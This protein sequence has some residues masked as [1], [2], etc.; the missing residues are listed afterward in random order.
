[1][2]S[3]SIHLQLNFQF[4]FVFVFLFFETKFHYVAFTGLE[5]V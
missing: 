1:M 4:C 5:L 2:L 3:E